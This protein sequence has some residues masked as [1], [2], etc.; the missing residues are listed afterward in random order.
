MSTSNEPTGPLRLDAISPALGSVGGGTRVD[1]TGGGMTSDV[2]VTI[3]GVACTS[4]M[5][6]SDSHASCVTG[7]AAFLEGPADVVVTRGGETQTL[8]GAYTYKCLW[9][10]SSG[11]TSCGAV[12]PIA[13]AA[14]QVDSFITQFQGDHG[15]TATV[16]G[17]AASSMADT[18]DFTLGTQSVFVDTNGIGGTSTIARTSMPAIDFTGKM[19]KVW[20]RVDNIAH[21]AALDIQIG[22]SNFSNAYVFNMKSTQG[23]QWITDGDWVSFSLSWDSNDT[24]TRGAPN[25]ANITDI[26]L[27][28]TD[29]ATGIPVRL[30]ANGLALVS[31][32]PQKYPHGVVSFTF[33][34]DWDTMMTEGKTILDAHQYPGTAFIIVDRIG[35]AGRASLSDLH[36]LDSDGWDI[37]A[38]AFT[39]VD[40]SKLFTNMTPAAIE[41]DMVSSREWLIDQ[42]FV[43]YDHCAYPSG[44]FEEIGQTNALPIA[45]RYFTTC[46]TIFSRQYESYPPSDPTKLRVFYALMSQNLAQAEAAIDDAR[47]YGDWVIIV[48]HKLVDVPTTTT[49]W[50]IADFTA[51]VDYVAQSGVA[52]D[53]I[54]GVMGN[55]PRAADARPIPN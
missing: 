55:G 14:Q 27:R 36:A 52:V 17:T 39:D 33:D 22:N 20:M 23:Q 40:H 5:S 34:D 44:E 43:G 48:N 2:V 9:Q 38:H 3:G 11:K 7:D 54:S 26:M 13:A 46:R 12:P 35:T 1:L 47:L 51:L 15:F 32:P 25:K 28:V 16:A 24:G 41:D 10:T 42:H 4:V 31:M 29:D 50:P 8:A 30:H 6:D 49:D 21:A 45:A 19:L 37:A 53:T 18:N